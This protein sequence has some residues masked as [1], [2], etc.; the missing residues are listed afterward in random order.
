MAT[1]TEG[2]WQDTGQWV[3]IRITEEEEFDARTRG[4]NWRSH[5]P[6]IKPEH[7]WIGFIGEAMVNAL[8]SDV[9]IECEVNGGADLL[10]D[11]VL[12]DSRG[13]EVKTR[14]RSSG[15][16]QPHYEVVYYAHYLHKP[17]PEI[18]MF[19]VYNL[20]ERT[21]TLLGGR[22]SVRFFTEASFRRGGDKAPGH[23]CPTPRDCF[24]LPAERLIS[25][26][27]LLENVA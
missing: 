1:A 18:L 16:F 27:A 11:L 23:D 9:G 13:I 26:P 22:S 8:L 6:T 19:N 17:I 24:A 4:K 25:F 12:P 3:A 15:V 2:R 7:R 10:P 20:A 21:L 5:D 14:S